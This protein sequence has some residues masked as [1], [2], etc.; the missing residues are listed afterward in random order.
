MGYIPL[1][2]TASRRPMPAP[3]PKEGRCSWAITRP[4]MKTALLGHKG[5]FWSGSLV[6]Y[7]DHSV[8][9]AGLCLASTRQVTNQ[10]V[11]LLDNGHRYK[12]HG[13]NGVF[14]KMFCPLE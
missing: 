8:E 11:F 3:I 7:L 2:K 4:V 9:D 6:S 1:I 10:Q 13:L 14:M 12:V 5:R